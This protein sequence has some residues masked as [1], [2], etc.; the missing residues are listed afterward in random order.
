MLFLVL[1]LLLW[2]GLHLFPASAAYK[3]KK[4]MHKTG[5]TPYKLGFA[6]LIVSSMVLMVIGWKWKMLP[7]HRAERW[8]FG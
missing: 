6:T 2:S 8:V 4:L 5:V 1:G 7:L 3:R